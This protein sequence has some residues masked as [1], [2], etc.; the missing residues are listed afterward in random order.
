MITRKDT[1]CRL[2]GEKGQKADEFVTRSQLV[3]GDSMEITPDGNYDLFFNSTLNFHIA[4]KTFNAASVKSS[5]S[6]A[7]EVLPSLLP[8]KY[9]A[10]HKITHKELYGSVAFNGGLGAAFIYAFDGIPYITGETTIGYGMDMIEDI[11]VLG[12]LVSAPSVLG[13]GFYCGLKNSDI[14]LGDGQIKVDIIYSIMDW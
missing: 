6:T 12:S 7:M 8:D 1:G 13:M 11:L 3:A 10:I 5:F 2:A 9:Y 4:S 14:A